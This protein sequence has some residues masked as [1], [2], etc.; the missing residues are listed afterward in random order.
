MSTNA[1][2]PQDAP[3][4]AEPLVSV[5]CVTYNHARFIRDALEGFLMQEAD[6]P[7]EVIVHD[8]CST[9]GTTELL[10][11]YEARFPG[12]LR[13][14]YEEENQFSK[15]KKMFALTFAEARGKYVALCEGDDYWTD[16]R[17]LAR[18]A[19]LMEAHP[20]YAFSFHPARW[21][22]HQGAEVVERKFAPPFVRESYTIDDL[23]EQGN[24]IP[25]C[26]TMFRGELLRDYPAWMYRTSYGDVALYL[27]AATRGRIGFVGEPMAAY[28]FHGAGAWGGQNYR[29]HLEGLTRTLRLVADNLHVGGRPSF[30]KGFARFSL[31]LHEMY[32]RERQWR[33]A[34]R[35][36]WAALKVA[37]A[38]QKPYILRAV[39]LRLPARYLRELLM[40]G[41][42]NDE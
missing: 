3:R 19:A 42:A 7:F 40:R 33:R 6:F 30:R 34:L 37:P 10:R 1:P 13:V 41:G 27:Y 28:R 15:G 26:S 18:Q 17:K 5:C 22:D 20:E 25:T 9:D 8:D 38:E 14:M 21:L 4:A 39:A 31:E 35:A 36:A 11:E 29:A 32:A 24:F 23:L 2:D 16:P 12:R